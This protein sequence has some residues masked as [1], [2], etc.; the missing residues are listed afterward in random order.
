MSRLST[1][2]CVFPVIIL[3]MPLSGCQFR[4]DLHLSGQLLVGPDQHPVQGA[5]IKVGQR[6]CHTD[7]D[8][9]WQLELSIGQ[10][11]V[12]KTSLGIV[13]ANSEEIVIEFD[14]QRVVVPFPVFQKPKSGID[15]YCSVLTIVNAEPARAVG[16]QA[17]ANAAQST[18]TEWTANRIVASSQSQ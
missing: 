2:I 15:I 1:A 10:R 17:T 8:G 5:V 14:E 16:E 13:P 18:A 4:Y 6:V 9:H 11:N 12:K 7:H 3:L